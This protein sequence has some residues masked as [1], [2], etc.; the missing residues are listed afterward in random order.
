MN[1]TTPSELGLYA[2]V[3][4]MTLSPKGRSVRIGFRRPYQTRREYVSLS[5]DE[6]RNR[7]VRV[8]DVAA[9]E[10]KAAGRYA[11]VRPVLEL[12]SADAEA[13]V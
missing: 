5:R 7:D 1:I 10:E 8:G 13:F 12:R 9:L 11:V 6:V 3:L 4:S 2:V